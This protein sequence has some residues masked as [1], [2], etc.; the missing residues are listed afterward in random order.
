MTI[1]IYDL[2]IN[3][4]LLWLDQKP[5]LNRFCP[6]SSFGICSSSL[7]L[8]SFSV[9]SYV[10]YMLLLIKK[11][12]FFVFKRTIYAYSL[13]FCH[14]TFQVSFDYL[15]WRNV[16]NMCVYIYA[17]WLFSFL[18]V[19]FIIVSCATYFSHNWSCE[20]TV[21]V[22]FRLLVFSP[23]YEKPYTSSLLWF[24]MMV[25]IWAYFSVRFPNEVRFN[26]Y[27]CFRCWHHGSTV[28]SWRK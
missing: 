23:R 24:L 9:F 14:V 27:G 21:S 25:K 26:R 4:Y 6:L 12:V 18:I 2:C 28:S 22:H 17:L 16:L 7:L 8:F 1:F 5:E 10:I 11:L 15:Y 19:A 3:C 13:T 20:W